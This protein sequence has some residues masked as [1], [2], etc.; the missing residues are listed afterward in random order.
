MAK[1]AVSQMAACQTTCAR[2]CQQPGRS[3]PLRDQSW[4]MRDG[5]NG[6]TAC[7]RGVGWGSVLLAPMAL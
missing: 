3:C 1:I 4:Y 7:G 6:V 5:K 2:V